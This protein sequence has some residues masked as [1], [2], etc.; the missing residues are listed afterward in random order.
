MTTEAQIQANR[1]NA[2]KSRGPKTEEGKAQA[3]LNALKHGMRSEE[4]GPLVA[5]HEDP[6]ELKDRI[7]SWLD[8]YQPAS[9]VERDLVERAARL[10]WTLDRI[11]R[12]ESALL[13]QRVRE[14]M[15]GRNAARVAEVCELSRRLFY[16]CGRREYPN[17][18]PEWNDNPW[19]FAVAL[20]ES[21]EGTQWM[22]D[23]WVELQALIDS[24]AAWSFRDQFKFI[25]LLGRHPADA[26]DDPELNAIVLAWETITPDWGAGFWKK[27]RET[28]PLEDPAFNAWRQW[29]A[30]VAPPESPEAGWAFLRSI[31]ERELDRLNERLSILEEVE[32]TDALE[33]AERALF[34]TSDGAERLRRFQS[35]RTRELL[36]TLDAIA[37]LR[38]AE[39]RAAK[40]PKKSPNEANPAADEAANAQGRGRE[41]ETKTPQKAPI[42]ANP[43]PDPEQPAP[44]ILLPPREGG[45]RP[46]EGRGVYGNALATVPCEPRSSQNPT[47]LTRPSGTFSRGERESNASSADASSVNPTTPASVERGDEMPLLADPRLKPEGGISILAWSRR[48]RPA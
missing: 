9:A 28:T 12:Y 47:A 6:A 37:K 5:P 43:A 48:F 4:F 34:S 32:G 26:V 18:G 29:R 20:E 14:A 40:T 21:V 3:R 7:E 17:P 38:K 30:L 19:A 36:R 11:E 31:V 46:D 15:V 13:A 24:G 44:S 22:I 25:R 41:V 2:Q 33:L 45:R 27:T 23:R 16:M 8:D 10:S 42:E 35:A 39:I 1:A